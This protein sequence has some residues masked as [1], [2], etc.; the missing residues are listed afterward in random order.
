MLQGAG[1][2][3]ENQ[4]GYP[5]SLGSLDN[6]KGKD[7]QSVKAAANDP[8]PPASE[9]DIDL[10]LENLRFD[11]TGAQLH[12]IDDE[13]DGVIRLVMRPMG[14]MA[15]AELAAAIDDH[16]A[17]LEGG[18]QAMALLEERIKV[19]EPATWLDWIKA[20]C[21][22]VEDDSKFVCKALDLLSPGDQEQAA[23]R[24]VAAWQA[25]AQAE[26]QSHRKANAGRRAANQTLL[27]ARNRPMAI[28]TQRQPITTTAAP[29]LPAGVKMAW[30]VRVGDKS[31]VLAGIPYTREQAQ[32]AAQ[33]R[34]PG[35]EVEV[36]E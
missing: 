7:C 3:L 31:L 15:S 11:F 34:W 1:E 6:N 13:L 33:A 10:L 2:I 25:A 8:E 12:D 24:Y 9:A 23:H 20:E 35:A 4:L 27:P 17:Q 18:L 29:S 5:G 28:G 36:V 30:T 21:S 26:P 16:L 22:L 32:R 14:R 19:Q